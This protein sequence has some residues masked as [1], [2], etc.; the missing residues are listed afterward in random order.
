MIFL[1]INTR[2]YAVKPFFDTQNTTDKLVRAG[3][4]IEK[5]RF[6]LSSKTSLRLMRSD[7]PIVGYSAPLMRI[8]Q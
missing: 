1:D 6:I 7:I 5:I 2:R 3:F 4:A 8:P